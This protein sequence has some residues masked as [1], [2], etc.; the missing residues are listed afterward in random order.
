MSWLAALGGTPDDVVFAAAVPYGE[1]SDYV[2][3]VCEG[4]ALARYLE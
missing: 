3:A 2:L 4:A 1:T